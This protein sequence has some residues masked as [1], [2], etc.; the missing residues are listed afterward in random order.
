MR[1]PRKYEDV[2]P[3]DMND[4]S[5]LVPLLASRKPHSK[6]RTRTFL[7]AVLSASRDAGPVR[8]LLDGLPV[9]AGFERHLARIVVGYSV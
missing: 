8:D 4:G 1:K 3:P 7:C 6:P 2:S 5:L 9:P